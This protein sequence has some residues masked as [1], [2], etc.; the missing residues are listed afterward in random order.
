MIFTPNPLYN[1]EF[2]EKITGR[3]KLAPGITLAKFL[4]GYGDQWT[5]NHIGN[6]DT[7]L[8]IAKHLS[9]HAHAMRTVATD[10]GEFADLRLI[11]AEGWYR[12]GPTEDLDPSSI[13][14][15]MTK[16]RA[17]VYE[18]IDEDGN[19]NLDKTFDLA[20]YW[21]DNLKFEKLILDY[22]TYEPDGSLNAQIILIM[23]E[24]SSTWEGNFKG[25]VETRYN[26][27]V[28]GTNELI[29][30]KQRKQTNVKIY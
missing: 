23:P 20:I 16:G 17:V 3:T 1:P 18:L 28:Q 5:I 9:M 22:D 7:R 12:V 19:I 25:N 26:N 29:E 13:N 8:E 27:Y 10:E 11:V 14:Y 4:G 6:R 21:K 30:V 24:L 2:Q 15:L